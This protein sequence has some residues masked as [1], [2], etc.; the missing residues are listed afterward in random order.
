MA[1]LL[2]TLL[3]FFLSGSFLEAALD[4]QRFQGMLKL[5]RELLQ[6]LRDYALA[7]KEKISVINGALREYN[8]EIDEANED[9]E[10]YLS[11]PLNAFRLIRHMHQDWVSWQVYMEQQVG[12]DQV[13]KLERILPQLPQR[14]DFQRAAQTMQSLVEFYAY[15]PSSLVA[16]EEFYSDLYLSPFDCYHMGLELYQEENYHEAIKWLTVAAENYT[17][18]PYSELYNVLGA[19][20]SE[21]YRMQARTYHKLNREEVYMAYQNAIILDEFNVHLLQESGVLELLSLRDPME[22]IVAPVTTPSPLQS[23]CRESV[24]AQSGVCAHNTMLSAFLTLARLRYE[25]V[26]L[27]PYIVIYRNAFY[28]TEVAHIR[29]ALKRC[30]LEAKFPILAGV[31][32]C[33]VPDEYS[34]VMKRLG[35]RVLDMTGSFKPADSFHVLEYAQPE[36]FRLFQLFKESSKFS[37]L[38][39]NE[40][41]CTAIFFLNDVEVGGAITIP[42]YPMSVQPR[43]GDVLIT[44]HEG[45]FEHTVCPNVVGSGLVMV[46]F[47]YA[48]TEE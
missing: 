10:L 38:D 9:P 17:L 40:I 30:P 45:D 43:E 37:N 22:P 46:K 15:E 4:E 27:S 3:L 11:N 31:R 29:D 47:L 39:F 36:P 24:V 28:E 5:E 6:N 25:E 7:L 16:Q 34:P 33:S 8:E 26:L 44:F 14:Q 1:A 18:S 2:Y 35:E 42:H 13:A 23:Q 19:S 21:V 32:G 20:R 12:P 41:E 48:D